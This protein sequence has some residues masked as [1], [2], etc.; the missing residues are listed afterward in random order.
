MFSVIFVVGQNPVIDGGKSRN[1][2]VGH[3]KK[4]N[5]HAL[6]GSFQE[7]R[8]AGLCNSFKMMISPA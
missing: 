3:G 1:V 2:F 4:M 5:A 7:K 6:D 8:K